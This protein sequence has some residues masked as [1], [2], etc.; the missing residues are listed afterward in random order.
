[1]FFNQGKLYSLHLLDLQLFLLCKGG[2][3]TAGLVWIWSLLHTIKLRKILVICQ[4][5]GGINP[6]ISIRIMR[7]KLI[8]M[9]VLHY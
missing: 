5:C 9:R 4:I 8:N 6:L 1:M 2:S 3:F 7:T